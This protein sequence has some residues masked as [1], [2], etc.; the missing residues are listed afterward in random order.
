[1]GTLGYIVSD[2]KIRNIEG[3]VAQVDDLSK[4]EPSKPVLIVGW[5]AAKRHPMYRNVLDRRLSENV[6]WTF[7][8]TESRSDF[9]DDI[10][11]FYKYILDNILDNINYYYYNIFKL[12]YNNI[13]I[14]YNIIL[15]SEIILYYDNMIYIA[16]GSDVYGLS[17]SV[18]SYIGIKPEKVVGKLMSAGKNV[19]TEETKNIYRLM[20]YA[21]GKRYA[22]P[23]L[24]S[25]IY[26]C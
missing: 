10:A 1:M 23:V 12:R 20:R 11:N 26:G 24:Y 2:R 8:K 5:E 22:V 15:N 25:K 19:I 7:S 14:I 21:G 18:M 9:D 13:K 16:H 4:T 3:F 6:F 17:L